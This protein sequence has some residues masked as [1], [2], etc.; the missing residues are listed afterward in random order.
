MTNEQRA[1]LRAAGIKAAADAPPLTDS[2]IKGIAR[3]LASH[4]MNPAAV[5]I[6]IPNMLVGLPDDE[7]AAA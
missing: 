4:N 5:V 1:A 2:E 7:P 3:V 6:G